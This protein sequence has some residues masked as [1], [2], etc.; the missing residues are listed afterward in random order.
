MHTDGLQSN[1]QRFLQSRNDGVGDLVLDGENVGQFAVEGLRPEVAVVAGV[2][3]LCGNPH[4]VAGLAHTAFQDVINLQFAGDLGD[5]EVL[6]LVGKGRG[7]RGDLQ[8]IH[9][10]QQIKQFLGNAVGEKL[11]LGVGTHVHEGQDRD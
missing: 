1:T 11:L 8:T 9:P 10:H 5:V 6:A 3:Q 4:P 7:A 2:N